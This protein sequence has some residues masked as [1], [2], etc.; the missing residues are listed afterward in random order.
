MD[1]ERRIEV[2]FETTVSEFQRVLVW[3]Y[4]KR[5]LVE[6]SLMLVAGIPFCYFIGINLLKNVWAALAFI[7]TLLILFTLDIY[8]LIFKRA[9]ALK[10]ITEPAKTI[11]AEQGL[12]TVTKSV[13]TNRAWESYAKI[14]ETEKDFIFFHKENAFAAIPKRFFSSQSDVEKLRELVNSKLGE[15]AKLQN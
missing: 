2:E 8:K 1:F 5:L 10:Q 7:A 15:R 6:F 4:W 11:F 3:Y 9:E 14:Y 13:H 12:E